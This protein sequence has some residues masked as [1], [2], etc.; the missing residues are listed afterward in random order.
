MHFAPFRTVPFLTLLA[1]PAIAQTTV[2]PLVAP[3]ANYTVVAGSDT[4]APSARGS[5]GSPVNRSA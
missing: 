1:L 4:G 2:H 5:A 3:R